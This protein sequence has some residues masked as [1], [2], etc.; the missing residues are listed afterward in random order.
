MDDL[1]PSGDQSFFLELFSSAARTLTVE[2]RIPR[3]SGSANEKVAYEEALG[4]SYAGRRALVSMKHVGLNVAADPFVNSAL[5]GV[6]GGLVLVVADDPGMHSS[7]NEQD[8]RFYGEFAQ[9]PIFEPSTQQEAYDLTL[10]GLLLLRGGRP[11]GH[12][13]AGHAPGPQPRQRGPAPLPEDRRRP[14]GARARN[15]CPARRLDA[16]AGDRAPRFSRLL[17][18]Q[19]RLLEDS[20]NSGSNRLTLAGRRGVIAAGLAHNYVL[21]ALDGAGQFSILKI[22]HYPLPVALIRSSSTTA[23]RSSSWRGRLPVHRAPAERPAR[24]ARQGD[25]GKLTGDL[26]AT[27]EL[28]PDALWRRAGPAADADDPARWRISPAPAAALQGC[29]H[30]DSFKA[31]VEAT[32]GLR[33]PDPVQRHRLLHARRDAA[34]PRGARLRRHGRVDRDGPRRGAQAGVRPR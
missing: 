17:E 5:T 19:Q 3:E 25:P 30:A 11:A 29:P 13:P 33:P 22:G 6:N 1:L 18:L 15:R 23:T 9:I 21:E 28:T 31:I 32:V 8:S 20:E 26:P 16:G 10:A 4:M 24:R 14:P 2:A 34:L 27:G 12:D 7:Q